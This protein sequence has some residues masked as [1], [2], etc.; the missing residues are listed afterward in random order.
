MDEAIIGDNSIIASGSIIT[1]NKKFPN[2]S[3][4]IGSPAIKSRDITSNEINLITESANKYVIVA[5][6]H[7]Q[8]QE[9]QTQKIK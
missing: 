8:Y 7:K 4:I 6:E 9:N 3:L 2:N 5:R 1:K